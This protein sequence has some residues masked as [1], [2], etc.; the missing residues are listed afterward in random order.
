MNRPRNSTFAVLLALTF[1]YALALPAALADKI[2]RSAGTLEDVQ[3]RGITP[4][5]ADKE[6]QLTYLLNG[7]PATTDLSRI[8]RL[9]L[10]DDKPFT[11]ADAAYA[12]KKFP[13]SVDGYVRAMRGNVE[14]K[15]RYITPRLVDAAGRANRFDAALSAYLAFIRL[16]AVA[17]S[18]FKPTLP[19]RGSK[20]L[21]DAV[22]DTESAL[23]GA[24]T[25][26]QR[27]A[28]YS[29][30]LEIHTQRGDDAARGRVLEEIEK[31]SKTLGDNPQTRAIIAEVRL[32]QAR[33]MI[34]KKQFKEA[35]DTIQ[36][37]AE[38]FTER[39]Q[40]ATGM[41]IIAQAKQGLA[42]PDDR[43]AMLDAALAYMVVVSSF[44]DDDSRPFVGESLLRAADIHVAIKEVDTALGLYDSVVKDFA[45]T[46]LADEAAK[47]SADL[48]AKQPK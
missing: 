20:L 29:L 17:A 35:L 41:Y 18:Q 37:N 24:S 34:D 22:K 39:K 27:Q 33:S 38:R 47:K 19:E 11:D 4:A 23:K 46:P 26:E 45:G 2:F 40:V 14:W 43:E 36:A 30:L 10:T 25:N 16:D 48:K 9:E 6:A 21:E 13:E 44:R 8:I 1:V 5:T 12:A 28:Y 31:L 32:S 7:Q 15:V 42:K 3:I